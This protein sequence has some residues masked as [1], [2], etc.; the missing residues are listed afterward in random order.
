MSASPRSTARATLADVEALCREAAERAGLV[1]DFRQSNHEGTLV[2]WVQEGRAGIA[3]IVVNAAGYTHTSVAL[4][5]ALS[6]CRVPRVEV[7][8]S[9]IH[10]R[11]EFRHHSYLTEV[12][13]HHVIGHG[14]Q[15]YA[16]AIEWVARAPWSVT[17]R[18]SGAARSG[19]P[20]IEAWLVPGARGRRGAHVTARSCGPGAVLVDRA[21]RRDRCRPGLGQGERPVAGLRGRARARSSRRIVPG[22][23]RPARRRRPRA[24]VAGDRRPRAADVARR[25]AAAARRLGRRRQG[26]AVAQHV[27]ADHA[28]AVLATGVP[29]FP[30]EPDDVVAWVERPARRPPGAPGATTRGARRRR[31]GAGRRR[32]AGMHDAAERLAASGCRRAPAQR[33]PPR[34]RLPAARAVDAFID[35]GDARVDPPADPLRIPLWIMRNRLDLA[36]GRPGAATG[37][38]DAGL[39]PW[40][41]RWD[42]ATLR[43]LLARRRPHL[44][45]APG[46]VVVAAAGATCRC[47][48]ST[49]RSCGRRPSGSSTPRRPTPTPPRSPAE[50]ARWAA[51]GTPVTSE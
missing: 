11:E 43:G 21:A 42:R 29:A 31:G 1:V 37:A 9:D 14:V 4:R 3:G 27:L 8:I 19:G 5:D 23:V 35:L 46:G 6:A 36:A 12:C 28:D 10:A 39:E 22:A 49:S 41:E 24:R 34:Q 26:Y 18:P 13:D 51:G 15:G 47:G 20:S 16:E 17:S 48:W 40:T 38:V 2:D 7:H 25:D 32:A 30:E 50:P 33:P 44:V 45:P